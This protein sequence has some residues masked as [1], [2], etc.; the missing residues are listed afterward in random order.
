MRMAWLEAALDVLPGPRS[1]ICYQ[2][3]ASF[4]GYAKLIADEKGKAAS[5]CGEH[6][7][8]GEA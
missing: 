5:S 2:I 8:R 6:F 7:L 4:R 1:G 3:L